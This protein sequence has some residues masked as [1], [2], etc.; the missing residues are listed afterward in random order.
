LPSAARQTG[1]KRLIM[2]DTCA[3]RSSDW[4]FL[5][6]G[7]YSRRSVKP[8]WRVR[9]PGTFPCA[10]CPARTSALDAVAEA[11]HNPAAVWWGAFAVSVVIGGLAVPAPGEFVSGRA[12]RGLAA[13]RASGPSSV[14]G[15]AC[16][17]RAGRKGPPLFRP[18]SGHGLGHAPGNARWP[19]SP[20]TRPRVPAT[21][22]PYG[23]QPGRASSRLPR[24]VRFS[25]RTYPQ[26]ARIVRALCVVTGR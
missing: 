21:A 7:H 25:G 13:S 12:E 4:S 6:S 15:M 3:D 19:R 8:D 20:E 11:Y 26:L 14:G 1:S 18:V 2:P 24:T 10:G 22:R 5:R 17:A 16:T 23:G 9:A